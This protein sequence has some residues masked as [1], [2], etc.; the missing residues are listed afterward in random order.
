MMTPRH[1]GER[2]MSREVQTSR[3][4]SKTKGEASPLSALFLLMLPALLLSLACSP[5]RVT[6]PHGTTAV[7]RQLS[8]M[9]TTVTVSVEAVDHPTA[10]AASERAIRALEAA[11]ARLSTWREDSELSRFNRTDV[12]RPFLLSPKLAKN[13]HSAGYWWRE[14]EG[15]FDPGIGMLIEAWGL[16]RGGRVPQSG[17]LENALA[18]NGLTSLSLDGETATRLHPGFWIEEGGFGK[19]AGLDEAISAMK[20]PGVVGGVVNLGGQIALLG[21]GKEGTFGIADPDDRSRMALTVQIGRGSLATSGNSERAIEVAGVRYG[22]IL[23]PQHG[24]PARD[25]GSLTVWAPTAMAADC[26]STGLYV[27][28]PDTALA[29][30]FGRSDIET[31]ILERTPTGL[32]VRAT[33]G[34]QG[35]LSRNGKVAIEYVK[36]VA[37]SDQRP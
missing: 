29:W 32:R 11:E 2:L 36:R 3:T 30:T 37:A 4:V 15:A 16:R 22:H 35:R 19:G 18:C 12:G 26:L 23:D 14:T 6:P 10:L 33:S 20:G 31:L 24:R 1:T 34:W 17:E 13:L 25:F 27:M 9:G 28:G 8:L 21:D 7:D 5:P